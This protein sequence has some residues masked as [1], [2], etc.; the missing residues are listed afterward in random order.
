M[1]AD[2][3]GEGVIAI[4]RFTAVIDRRY[5]GWRPNNSLRPGDFT[6]KD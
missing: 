1:T 4:A 6:P 5:R 3:F 2:R